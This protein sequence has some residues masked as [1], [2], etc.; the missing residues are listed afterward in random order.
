M[1]FQI[2]DTVSVLDDAIDGVIIAIN[3][4]EITIE[5]DDGFPM[6]Y[7]SEKLVRKGELP[8][9]LKGFE[10]AI[11]QKE[12][13]RRPQ[14]GV[15]HVDEYVKV[16]DLHIE[17][18]VR[19]KGGM[20]NF[21]ILNLQLDTAKY[22]LEQAIQKRLPKIVFIHGVGDGVLREDLHS[23]FRRYDNIRF[24]EASYRLY[25]QGATEV[26]ILQRK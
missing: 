3:G 13:K 9:V 16:L 19:K 18:L 21:Q 8:N 10:Q 22:H 5:S 11:K 12:A 2:N 4:N 26:R 24:E 6:K 25:G 23:M 20:S 7:A 15:S 1:K 17:K 14:Q